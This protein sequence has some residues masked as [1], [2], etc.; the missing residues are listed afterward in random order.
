MQLHNVM[1]YGNGVIVLYNILYNNYKLWFIIIYNTMK[2]K[3]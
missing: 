3:K 1:K 2:Y